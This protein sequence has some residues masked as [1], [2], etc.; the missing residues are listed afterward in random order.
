MD[1]RIEIISIESKNDDTI[2]SSGGLEYIA[3]GSLWLSQQYGGGLTYI[4]VLTGA[5]VLLLNAYT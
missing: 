5:V 1:D 4:I 3:S 2:L